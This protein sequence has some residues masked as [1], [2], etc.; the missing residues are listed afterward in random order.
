VNTTD[1]DGD[2]QII[3]YPTADYKIDGTSGESPSVALLDKTLTEPHII[4]GSQKPWLDSSGAAV[5][6]ETP[7]LADGTHRIDIT[8]TAANDT[9]LFALDYF[10]IT[11]TTG[12]SVSGVE[13][14]RSMPSSTSTS[15]SLPI[16]TA[17]TAPVGAIVGG[18]VG[19]IAGIA[20]LVLA[21]WYFLKKRTS[22]GQAYYFDK[23]SPADMLASE[24]LYTFHRMY[25]REH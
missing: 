9:N 10:L 4:A 5:Y 16:V 13:T 24:G 19:G 8:V 17:K 20:I 11:P 15:S 21:I 18:V 3:S 6:F 2:E 23:P 22:G 12:G 14:S 25:C 7:K 1:A